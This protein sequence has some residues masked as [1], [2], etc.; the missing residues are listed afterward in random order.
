MLVLF[1]QFK[2]IELIKYKFFP[3]LSQI[4]TVFIADKEFGIRFFGH[5]DHVYKMHANSLT[6]LIDPRYTAIIESNRAKRGYENALGEMQIVLNAMKNTMEK[7]IIMTRS[8][9]LTLKNN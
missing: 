4:T 2:S 3:H 7:K 6:A 5:G 8:R 1:N 9:T